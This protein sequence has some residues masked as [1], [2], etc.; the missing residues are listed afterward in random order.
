MT[1]ANNH[2]P[3]KLKESLAPVH[4]PKLEKTPVPDLPRWRIEPAR[5]L[6]WGGG[7][8]FA[9]AAITFM[10]QGVYSFAPMTRHWLML[11]LC[12]LLGLIGVSTGTFLKDEK[13]ARVFLGF[14][15]VSFPVLSSQL[16]AMLYSIFGKPPLGMPQPLVF[17][18]ANTSKI[19]VVTALT[20]AIAIP[21]SHLAF[22]ILARSK[23][24]LMTW[25][26]TFANLCILLPLRETT[27]LSTIIFL[28]AGAIF[29]ADST[30]FHKDF[31]LDNFEGRVS[32]LIL[33]TPLLVIISRTYFYSMSFNFYGFIL[34]LAG[35]YLAFF[36]GKVA[37]KAGAKLLLQIIGQI[38]VIAGWLI[39]LMSILDSFTLGKG[40]AVYLALLPIALSFGTQSLQAE[41][42]MA[43]QYRN[44]AAIGALLSVIVA[45]W[46]GATPMV[47][48][49]GVLVSLVIV[50]AG[51]L[52]G[53]K[54]LFAVGVLAAVVSLG[55]FGF[56][57]IKLHSN[58]AWV[59][60]A[61][62]GIAIMFSASLFEKKNA[63]PFF[64]D[65]PL[66]GRLKAR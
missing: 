3:E 48:V 22:K 50:C 60:L 30:Q 51:T 42:R 52:A 41:Q 2:K 34:I 53:E 55:N 32:R 64:K 11:T 46:C 33:V 23:S 26:F 31:R 35:A 12:G 20:L 18:L 15:A 47:S 61:L 37:K 54:L 19:A 58:Y 43:R 1:T 49:L 29:W 38:G 8:V 56:Q 17:S 7:I 65:N 16:G 62:I 5:A 13:G 44:T 36:W 59:A 14:A 9:I 27:W 45:H 21:V 63:L 6:R 25:L 10:L 40:M 57:A 39:C 24:V 4:H 66:W 28:A